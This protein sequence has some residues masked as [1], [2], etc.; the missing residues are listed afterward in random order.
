VYK[1]Q[2]PIFVRVDVES[3]IDEAIDKAYEVV[4]RHLRKL[5]KGKGNEGREE[6]EEASGKSK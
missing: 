3:L 6:A 2:V 5:A 4:E 1:R